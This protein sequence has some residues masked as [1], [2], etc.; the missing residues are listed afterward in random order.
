[1]TLYVT[2]LLEKPPSIAQLEAFHAAVAEVSDRFPTRDIIGL[3]LSQP[4]NRM[5]ATHAT[6]WLN[7][8]NPVFYATF[9]VA[10]KSPPGAFHVPQVKETHPK[11]IHSI[12][13]F[14]LHRG[15]SYRVR[16]RN[17][18]AC[19]RVTRRRRKQRTARESEA[20]DRR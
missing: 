3:V 6:R 17:G 11:F 19:N 10:K 18:C 16:S 14:M 9:K 12:R 20:K 7:A 13:E 15:G 1:M 8:Y 5:L 4:R 2:F